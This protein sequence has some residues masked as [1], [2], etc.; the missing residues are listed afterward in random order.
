MSYEPATEGQ[1]SGP[2]ATGIAE[3]CDY[4]GGHAGPLGCLAV[5]T[6]T[7]ESAA[8][9]ERRS[10]DRRM[11][12]KFVVRERRTG[13]DRRN[14]RRVGRIGAALD[15]SLVY[16]RDNASVVLAVLLTANLLSILDLVFT[17]RAL[18]NGAQEGNPLM[19]AL[20]D[21]NPAVAGCVK[22][23]IILGLS[24]LIWR[25]RRYRMIL[26][27]ALFALVMYGGIIAYHIYCLIY[28][29]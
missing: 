20:L 16:L 23:G 28:L 8:A 26:Q 29:A 12:R 25:L 3:A 5:E 18:Q 21:W 1:K 17:L 10:V 19:K 4:C 27:V 7:A 11:S 22:V 15:S 24:L 14:P 2:L 13:F 9:T 6:G